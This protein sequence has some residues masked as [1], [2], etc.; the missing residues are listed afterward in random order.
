MARKT[1]LPSPENEIIL[2]CQ[3][4]HCPNCGQKMWHG[5]DN[6]RMVRTLDGMV[7]LRLKVRRC[8]NKNC[9]RYKK[10]YRPECE[11]NW[12]LPVH[13]FGFD[14][15]AY[16]G[17]LRYQEHRS[18]TQIHKI[19]TD[20][21]IIISVR[22]V[23]NLL[24]RYDELLSVSL[25]DSE[26]IKKVISTQENVVLAIDGMQPDVGHEVLWVIR[27]CISQEILLAKTILSSRGED[28]QELLKEVAE[29]LSVPIKGIVS[30]GQPS[31]RKA[32]REA[33]PNIP[34]GLCHFHYLREA[35][36]PIYEADRHAKK[37]LKKGIRGIRAIE[38][39]IQKKDLPLNQ[40]IQGYCSAVR[41]A[42]T[43]DGRPPLCASGLKLRERLTKITESI[44]KMS[45][46]GY[47][48][49]HY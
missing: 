27:D 42:I 38:R 22:S 49:N 18:V 28:L 34:H 45:K 14:V 17:A 31:I 7:K 40:V 16:I 4:H 39:S 20:K 48:L 21:G 44:S 9:S 33:F 36:K 1:A 23:P 35:A 30:D 46:R 8:Q 13:E 6:E 29:Q 10:P 41:S 15:V 26:R 5:Y 11:G 37:L 12:A 2:E 24:D 47:Y 25:T 19:L 32:V 43:D 3:F